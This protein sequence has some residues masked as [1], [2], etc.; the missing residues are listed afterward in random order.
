MNEENN[1]PSISSESEEEFFRF[2]LKKTSLMA[3]F[4]PVFFLIGLFFGYQIWG[5]NPQP[6]IEAVVPS[7][8]QNEVAVEE[9]QPEDTEVAQQP[10]RIDVLINENDPSFGP[11]DA[12]VTIIEFSDYECPYCRRHFLETAGPLLDKYEGQLRLV[13]KDFPLT[14][15]HPNAI[16]ASAAALCAQEQDAYWPFHDLLFE[17]SLGFS[18]DTYLAYANSLDLDME[19]FT[20]CEAEGRYIETV[21]ANLD[22]GLSLGVRSTP[23]FL[24]NGIPLVGA[25][26]LEEFTRI[27]DSE[28][29]NN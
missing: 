10:T 8:T 14:S 26:P 12:P 6:V 25:Q 15:I 28:L 23:T 20:E 21:N 22:Y 5:K 16:P 1:T 13:F 11:E 4:F 29:N 9:N 24:I 19:S 2:T 18:Q 3:L 17:M 27:I 7:Q